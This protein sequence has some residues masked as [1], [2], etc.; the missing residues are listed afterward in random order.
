MLKITDARDTRVSH[1]LTCHYNVITCHYIK[2][3][4]SFLWQIG[5]KLNLPVFGCG[6]RCIFICDV[7]FFLSERVLRKNVLCCVDNTKQTGHTLARH[8]GGRPV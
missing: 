6:H 8:P 4:I 3:G 7:W 1:V 2:K 5:N